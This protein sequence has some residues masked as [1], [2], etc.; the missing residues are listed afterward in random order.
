V[1][2]GA[3]SVV[4]SAHTIH[5]GAFEEVDVVADDTHTA[6]GFAAADWPAANFGSGGFNASGTGARAGDV[7][8]GHFPG[9]E[10][11]DN[12]GS[13]SNYLYSLPDDDDDFTP[14][15]SPHNAA[16][17]GSGGDDGVDRGIIYALTSAE[18]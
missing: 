15:I 5:A 17:G 18:R 16:P 8:D 6:G 12:S 9:L 7:D 3:H 2:G 14:L 11:R 10:G 4:S 1:G 13:P